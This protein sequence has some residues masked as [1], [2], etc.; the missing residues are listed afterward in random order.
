LNCVAGIPE[1]VRLYIEKN[2]PKYLQAPTTFEEPN[3]TSWTC[4]KKVLDDRR[5]SK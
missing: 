3:E 1:P 4:F 2:K 5:K